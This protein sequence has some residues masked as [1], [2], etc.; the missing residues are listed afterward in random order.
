MVIAECKIP[1]VIP[2]LSYKPSKEN[3]KSVSK[4]LVPY[5]FEDEL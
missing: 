5:N 1:A 2:L 4:N 3:K